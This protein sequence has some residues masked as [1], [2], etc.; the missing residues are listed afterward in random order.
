MASDVV[1]RFLLGSEIIDEKAA[2]A[3]AHSDADAILVK[4]DGS[5]GEL[6]LYAHD[7]LLGLGVAADPLLVQAHGDSQRVVNWAEGEAR[8]RAEVGREAEQA[9]ICVTIPK[10]DHSAL[11]TRPQERGLI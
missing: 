11:T 8:G 2:S 10:R 5:E 1:D 6:A 3:R 7:L 4:V 9:L